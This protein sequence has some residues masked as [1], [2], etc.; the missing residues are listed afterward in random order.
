[1]AE[2]STDCGIYS[3]GAGCPIF[4][5]Y[6]YCGNKFFARIRSKIPSGRK[7]M[8]QIIRPYWGHVDA[9]PYV[10]DDKEVG[11]SLETEPLSTVRKA[12]DEIQSLCGDQTNYNVQLLHTSKNDIQHNSTQ[13][14]E[15]TL[16]G[17]TL[18]LSQSVK[19]KLDQNNDIT[20]LG[21]EFLDQQDSN[22]NHSD[23]I[24][25]ST[26]VV[27]TAADSLTMDNDKNNIAPI[28]VGEYYLRTM[29][30]VW[31]AWHYFSTPDT[32]VNS[33]NETATKSTTD[34]LYPTYDE[35]DMER[36]E[37]EYKMQQI[38]TEYNDPNSTRHRDDL[39]QEMEQ[40][41]K[42]LRQY[43]KRARWSR[44]KSWLSP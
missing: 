16:A 12:Q 41:K 27:G 21:L 13:K 7:L 42:E 4:D 26:L 25:D 18:V 9:H 43:Q 28:S 2:I 10:D 30:T 22:P 35:A 14:Q 39:I 17:S 6:T 38:Q 44:V 31:S 3:I 1:M 19:T 8:D 15:L 29:T 5:R 11:T 20:V 33:S 36:L 32:N 23:D 37:M 34:E 40:C 24:N